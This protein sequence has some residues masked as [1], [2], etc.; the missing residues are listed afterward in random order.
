MK[1]SLLS[2]SLTL[3]RIPEDEEVQVIQTTDTQDTVKIHNIK[4]GDI[5]YDDE[6]YDYDPLLEDDESIE[7]DEGD[8]INDIE[9]D[10][11]RVPSDIGSPKDVRDAPGSHSSSSSYKTGGITNKDS[12][13]D[14]NQPTKE[15]LDSLQKEREEEEEEEERKLKKEMNTT[16][17]AFLAY[18]MAVLHLVH[19]QSPSSTQ[20]IR[21][22]SSNT[23]D[24][25][26]NDDD[27]GTTTTTTTNDAD[28]SNDEERQKE[29]EKK[30]AEDR[31]ERMEE[32]A[33]NIIETKAKTFH[34]AI[35][36]AQ[37]WRKR[38][39]ARDSKYHHVLQMQRSSNSDQLFFLQREVKMSLQ[40]GAKEYQSRRDLEKIKRT[41]NEVQQESRME[42]EE[43]KT[44]THQTTSSSSTP[45]MKQ[46]SKSTTH[47]KSCNESSQQSS[48]PYY[49][50][51]KTIK[52]SRHADCILSTLPPFEYKPLHNKEDS[53]E[54][55][56]NEEKEPCTPI[57]Y[58][59][60]T[61]IQ[62]T[63]R[64]RRLRRQYMMDT[65]QTCGCPDCFDEMTNFDFVKK[66]IATGASS[67]F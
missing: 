41:E 1:D 50:P 38:R 3:E 23:S 51:Y 44:S 67:L 61:W 39:D 66:A 37:E 36:T 43:E 13:N 25:S 19:N 42:S 2:E 7:S 20:R 8:S 32:A 18:R 48:S 6:E 28:E 47:I 40:K 52:K 5:S 60:F 14:N 33:R 46:K 29:I 21:S 65:R 64:W 15:M 17:V 26:D 63:S 58:E 22:T 55:N 16:K 45:I 24:K 62:E 9:Y 53:I 54:K 30:D 12:S 4:S 27:D 49:V 59:T 31:I 35:S 34:H 57:K 11:Y 56:D 10:H